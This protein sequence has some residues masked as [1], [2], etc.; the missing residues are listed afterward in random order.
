MSD[1]ISRE[2]VLKYPIRLDHYDEEHGN[3]HFVLGIES[4]MEYVE[5]L[6]SAGQNCVLCEY[7]TEIETDDGIKGKC[8]RRTGSD[9]ISRQDAINCCACL[10]PEECW[11]EI[12]KL[13]SADRTTGKWKHVDLL[14][15]RLCS[16]CGYGVWD[17]E[18]E[19]YNYCP[20]CGARMYKGGDD[21]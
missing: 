5:S 15:D 12:R 7:Y 13:P 14:A 6:P 16:V 9:L 19:E 17:F 1:L 11:N 21:E 8:T 20:N 2:D 4:V 18:A 10:H 3:R